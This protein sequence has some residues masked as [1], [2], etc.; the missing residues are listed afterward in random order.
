MP[1]HK[2]SERALVFL[3]GLFFIFGLCFDYAIAQKI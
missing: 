1:S 3:I 2:F